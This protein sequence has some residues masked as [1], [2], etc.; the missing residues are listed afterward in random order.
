MASES[1]RLPESDREGD[2]PHPRET[3]TLVGHSQAERLLAESLCGARPPHAWLIG[4]PKGVGKATLAYRFARAALSGR[5]IDL[6]ADHPLGMP[7]VDAIFRHVAAGTH[8]DL[9]VLRRPYDEKTKR[10][11]TQLPV[12]EV[13]R[14]YPF[15]GR[16]AGEGGYRICIVDSADDL[17]ASAANALL[18]LLEEP[19]PRSIFLILAHA[20][21]RLIATIRSRCRRLLLK[22]VEEDEIVTLVTRA[23][24]DLNEAERRAI[25]RLAEG[26]P[27][28]ALALAE[29]EGLA[30][31]REV[32][33]L[34]AR[35]PDL[36]AQRLHS[37]AERLA[38]PAEEQAYEQAVSFMRGWLSRITREAARLPKT[39]I[40]AGEGKAL[41]RLSARA[42]IERWSS[43]WERASALVK[44]AD[45]LALDRK[46]VLLSIAY[47]AAR[48]AQGLPAEL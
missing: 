37:F 47:G 42:G 9:L 6:D 12:D 30:L 10:I 3:E 11:K 35:L 24:S 28:R 44:R 41:A 13:R 46:Q 2:L 34:F 17:S 33:G 20:P 21:A 5:A 14:I 19:P 48:T 43:L 7:A 22:P 16:H 4:G 23:A 36:D 32:A 40:L 26:C 8:P 15:F 1:A 27:G 25:A 29:G 18:K 45:A 38:R 39:E 31:Y